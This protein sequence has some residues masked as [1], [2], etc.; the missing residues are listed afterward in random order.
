MLGLACLPMPATFLPANPITPRTPAQRHPPSP[1]V[2]DV[3]SYEA[4][5]AFV[6]AVHEGSGVAHFIVHARKCH[7]KGLNPHQNRTVPPLRYQWV[8]ALKRDFPHLH[9]SLNG[10]VL[11]LEETAAALRLVDDGSGGG[12]EAAEAEAGAAP[13]GDAEAAAAAAEAAAEAAEADGGAGAAEAESAV[14]PGAS[15]G[16]SGHAGV[17][18]V[19][20]GRAAYNMPWDVLGECSVQ[21]RAGRGGGG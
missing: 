17:L 8:W 18:G 16:S 3:D 11:T 2:D 20:V 21:G 10:G 9:F 13:G 7:L 5:A 14:P 12:A 19:M 4:L 1:G 6:R 15:A